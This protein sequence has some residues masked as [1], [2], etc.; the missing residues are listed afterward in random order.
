MPHTECL[1]KTAFHKT[2]MCMYKW[3]YWL[4]FFF[5]KKISMLMS[6]EYKEAY[7]SLTHI[8]MIKQINNINLTKDELPSVTIQT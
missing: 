1:I 6:V 4:A 3:S 7:S 2:V 5:K 8:H